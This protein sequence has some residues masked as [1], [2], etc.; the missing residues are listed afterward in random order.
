MKNTQ[1]LLLW[2]DNNWKEI[3]INNEDRF[4]HFHNI[5]QTGMWKTEM[6]KNMI[7]QDIHNWKWVCVFDNHWDLAEDI[8]K[9]IPKERIND[10]IIFNPSDI[11][12]PLW[13]NIF[14]AETEEEKEIAVSN[15]LNIMIQL[16]GN[17]V[18]W[19]RLQDYFRNAAFT[20]IDY[21]EWWTLI[22][23]VKIFT[24]EEF[25]KDCVR[26]VKNVIVKHWWENTYYKMWERERSEIIPYF[27]A[28]F[29]QFNT[30]KIMRNI[31]G[32]TKSSFDLK[33]LIQNNKILLINISKWRIWELNSELLW[34]ILLSK[35]EQA[36]SARD[37]LINRN[38]R[39]DFYLYI[40][41]AQSYITS[42]LESLLSNGRKWGISVNIAHQYLAQLEKNN[43]LSKTNPDI[44]NSIFSN[45]WN[46]L[47]FRLGYRDAEIMSK[48]Y[49]PEFIQSDLINLK[50]F[51]WVVKL[52][53]S[54]KSKIITPLDISKIYNKSNLEK[55]IIKLSRLKYWK[56]IEYINKKIE[57]TY[58][59]EK[60]DEKEVK[61][62]DW[63]EWKIK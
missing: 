3:K 7:I 60:D 8:L 59:V 62:P 15:A 13:L 36:S 54:N 56:E 10:V 44:L 53:N 57:A 35:I 31:L 23:I 52:L 40:D 47:S 48:Y 38:E 18:F 6:L 26:H 61:I 24:D 51:E 22:D 16:F 33:D 41:E 9:Y 58:S 50:K 11:N 5:G 39:K 20:L 49:S 14:E 43:P 34:M 29:G 55:E 63:L 37:A 12:K 28:K 25:Q 17:E 1:W 21:P 32:Q 19:P 30:S 2:H 4:M 46:I 45:I 42:S 27:A